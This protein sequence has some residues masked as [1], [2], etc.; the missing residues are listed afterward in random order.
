MWIRVMVIWFAALLGVSAFELP[1]KSTQCVLGITED[2]NSSH[3]T[4]ALYQR[5]GS[6]WR[7][8]GG[9][10]KARL[11]KN[12]SAWGLGLHAPP[13]GVKLKQEGDLRAPV[14]VFGIGG[15]WGYDRSIR[16]HPSMPYRQVTPRDLWVED[17]ESRWYNRHLVLDHD[18][19]TAWE[20]KQQMKQDD[21][22]HALKLFIAHNAAPKVVKGA[23]SSIFF[24]IWRDGGGR[25]SAGCTTM[26]EGRLRWLISNIDPSARP[27]YVLLPRSEYEKRRK[28][29]GLP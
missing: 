24:H 25:P 15:V 28:A 1:L 21:P 3:A 11:G 23:G 5:S 16:K 9:T 26:D 7:Q 2:W 27:V 22:A 29:W 14:G 8:V 17:P 12:G 20:K 6:G 10:W 13:K 4:L 19:R 18:P